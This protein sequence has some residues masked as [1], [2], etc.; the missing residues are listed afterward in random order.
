MRIEYRFIDFKYRKSQRQTN[1]VRQKRCGRLASSIVFFILFNCITVTVSSNITLTHINIA[2]LQA[3]P[4]MLGAS[5]L[6]STVS[7]GTLHAV[8]E[9]HCFAQALIKILEASL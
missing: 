3:K 8:H 6:Y 4:R 9:F 1:L 2:I 5:V 7:P